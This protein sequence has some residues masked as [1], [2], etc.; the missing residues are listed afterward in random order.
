[1]QSVQTGSRRVLLALAGA[2]VLLGPGNICLSE[3]PPKDF[4]RPELVAITWRP[5]K[6]R[7][8]KA[9]EKVWR[10]NGEFLPPEEI[11]WLHKSG[12]F[13]ARVQW[14]GA[15]PQLPT[16]QMIFKMD[17][18]TPHNADIAPALQIG[19]RTIN[20]GAGG[21][22]KKG[23]FDSATVSPSIAELSAWPAHVN[24][25]LQVPTTEPVVVCR[26]EP[27]S[28][29][30]HYSDMP[31]EIERGVTWRFDPARPRRAFKGTY[32]AGILAVDRKGADESSEWAQ[33][34]MY[35]GGE[36]RKA[37]IREDVGST[38]ERISQIHDGRSIDEIIVEKYHVRVERYEQV[39]THLE[40]LP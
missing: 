26:I 30:K 19:D 23:G 17:E 5:A 3:T 32:A 39:P 7:F 29:A 31:L 10:A 8:Q 13:G 11:D 38:V 21:P 18:S 36:L 25:S 40:L 28:R 37:E 20:T 22:L 33:K 16:L 34:V 4:R 6:E 15:E 24:I 12:A 27:H 1:M 14:L 2:I 35:A 9:P